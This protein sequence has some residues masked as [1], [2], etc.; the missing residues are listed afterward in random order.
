MKA[1]YPGPAVPAA[2]KDQASTHPI[3]GEIKPGVLEWPDHLAG[4]VKAAIVAGLLA[5]E[6]AEAEKAPKGKKSQ[7]Q[8]A[9]T[10]AA[11]KE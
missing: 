6:G 9:D 5:P 4:E 3:L 10:T 7:N 8:P 11:E 2:M 1:I